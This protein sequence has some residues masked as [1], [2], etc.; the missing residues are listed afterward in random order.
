MRGLKES[1]R[2]LFFS[3]DSVSDPRLGDLI[4]S[5]SNF[6]VAGHVL[7]GYPDDE[8]IRNN[9]GRVGASAG[10]SQIRKFLYKMTPGTEGDFLSRESDPLISDLGDLD[11]SADSLEERH[12]SALSIVGDCLK[13][14]LTVTTLGGGHDYGFPDGAAYCDWCLQNQKTPILINFDAHLDVRAPS[15]SINSGTPFYRLLG[16]YPTA[17]LYEIGIQ[18]Q[19]NSRG[20][21]EWVESRGGKIL[22][23]SDLLLGSSTPDIAIFSALENVLLS[24]TSVYLSLDMDVFSS[25]YA[26][27]CSQSWPMGMN[28][29]DMFRVLE[30][31]F[32]RLHVP[33]FGV[34]EVSPPLDVADGTSKLAAQ[35]VHKRFSHLHSA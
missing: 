7:L 22:F 33:V 23:Q 29:R 30:V 20:H 2:D 4:R 1:S 17:V 12:A 34:Y 5:V 28:P 31:F 32:S 27:G 16:K 15:P 18:D 19:C 13:R 10:P 9:G 35:L 21:V 8:G 25:V 3:R 24:K 14:G 6:P 26:P 11:V